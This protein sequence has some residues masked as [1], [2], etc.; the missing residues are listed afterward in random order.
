MMPCTQEESTTTKMVDSE[1]VS[2]EVAATVGVVDSEVVAA[3][4][5]VVIE[6][7]VIEEDTIT[8]TP[9]RAEDHLEM[10]AVMEVI[11]TEGSTELIILNSN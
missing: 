10:K 9:I 8:E 1:V 4:E 3:T 6:E 5:E 2:V 11:I 7:A